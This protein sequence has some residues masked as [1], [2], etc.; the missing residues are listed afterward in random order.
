MNESCRGVEKNYHKRKYRRVGNISHYVRVT[1][2]ATRDPPL[3]TC[4]QNILAFHL[5]KLNLGDDSCKR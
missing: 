5:R 1:F 3:C 4:C 2:F